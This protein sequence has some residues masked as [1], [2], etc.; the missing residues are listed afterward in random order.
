MSDEHGGLV[1]KQCCVLGS[2]QSSRA[3]PICGSCMPSDHKAASKYGKAASASVH[4]QVPPWKHGK[5]AAYSSS[6]VRGGAETSLLRALIAQMKR[7]WCLFPVN[8]PNAVISDCD[9]RFLSNRLSTVFFPPQLPGCSSSSLSVKPLNSAE[10][11]SASQYTIRC[12]ATQKR[13]TSHRAS[14]FL[15]AE[16]TNNVKFLTA[17]AM[18]W[19][20][21]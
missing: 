3:G 13:I 6:P 18:W 5:N 12:E 15:K 2:Q 20:L 16:H 4:I 11:L 1:D 9:R 19:L 14:G 17:P 21:K 7:I 10:R 8:A